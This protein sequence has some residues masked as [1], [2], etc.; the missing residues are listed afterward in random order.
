M[1]TKA[2]TVRQAQELANTLK[3]KKYSYQAEEIEQKVREA[4]QER[5]QLVTLDSQPLIDAYDLFLKTI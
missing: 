2:I 3:A 1:K 5:V 4:V